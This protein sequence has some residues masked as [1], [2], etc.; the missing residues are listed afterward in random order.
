MNRMQVSKVL[1]IFNIL[2]ACEI[3]P[4]NKEEPLWHEMLNSSRKYSLESSGEIRAATLNKLVE[5]ATSHEYLGVL[6]N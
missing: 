3:Q 4:E 1:F 6:S 5:L 2:L